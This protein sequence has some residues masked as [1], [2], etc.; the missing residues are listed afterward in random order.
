MQVYVFSVDQESVRV[1]APCLDRALHYVPDGAPL[2]NKYI[3]QG[4]WADEGILYSI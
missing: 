3:L 1:Y 2:I 4:M